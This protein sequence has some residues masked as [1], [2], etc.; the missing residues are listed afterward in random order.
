MIELACCKSF[1]FQKFP[2]SQLDLVLGRM[3]VGQSDI[4]AQNRIAKH[5]WEL[6][7]FD[8]HVSMMNSTSYTVSNAL[9]L[10]FVLT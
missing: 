8:M 9:S 3:T 10:Y 1:A 2:I 6:I 5:G 4:E 7:V